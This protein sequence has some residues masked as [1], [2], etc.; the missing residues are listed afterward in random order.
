M[1]DYI[2]NRFVLLWRDNPYQI[3]LSIPFHLNISWFS[4]HSGEQT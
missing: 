4:D 2:F 3:K 1:Y